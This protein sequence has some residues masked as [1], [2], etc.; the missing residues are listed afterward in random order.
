M[1]SPIDQTHHIEQSEDDNDKEIK[2]LN[3]TQQMLEKELEA[4]ARKDQTI[5]KLKDDKC[6]ANYLLDLKDREIASLEEKL[7]QCRMNLNS[8]VE[9]AQLAEALLFELRQEIKHKDGW[10]HP[11]INP[12]RVDTNSKMTS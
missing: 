11:I 7:D 1:S 10:R 2:R 4:S 6:S 12:Q 9:R 5:E 3:A 8:W